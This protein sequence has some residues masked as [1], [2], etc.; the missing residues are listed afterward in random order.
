MIEFLNLSK[1]YSA[2]GTQAVR[3]LT[4]SIAP[5]EF[6]VLIGPSGSGKTT[7]LNMVNRLVEPD[8]GEIRIEGK[9]VLDSDPVMLRRSIG[10]VFQEAGLFPHMTVAENVAAT[11]VLLGWDRPRIAAR[12]TQLLDMVQLAGFESRFPQEL[13]GGQRQ[14]VALARALA[15]RPPVLLLDE[16]FGA[17]DPVTREAVAADVR[18]IHQ[19]LG[20]TTLMVTHDMTEALLMADRIA[21]MADGQLVQVGSPRELVEHPAD[22][23]VA[24]LIET[25]RRRARAL[26]ETL[27]A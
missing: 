6:L 2:S 11:P 18:A 20:L 13:S 16:P 21:V 8:S 1:A 9:N 12:V 23:F 14:R 27:R 4:L 5:G 22:A 24:Q 10:Y 15:A 26:A 7:T 25:P 19:R 3:G 17:L